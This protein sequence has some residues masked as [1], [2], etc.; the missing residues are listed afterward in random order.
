MNEEIKEMY[1]L[2][3]TKKEIMQKFNINRFFVR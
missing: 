2:K 3:K 1:L